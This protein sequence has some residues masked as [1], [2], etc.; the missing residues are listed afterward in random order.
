MLTPITL[1]K[2]I[3][4]IYP[5]TGQEKETE[6]Q[7]EKPQCIQGHSIAR[8]AAQGSRFRNQVCSPDTTVTHKFVHYS[9]LQGGEGGWGLGLCL[10]SQI[11][12]LGS[13]ASGPTLDP[14]PRP[15]SLRPDKTPGTSYHISPTPL[16][17]KALKEKSPIGLSGSCLSSSAIACNYGSI[18]HDASLVHKV[19]L[20]E[21]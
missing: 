7:R 20:G 8:T 4:A 14:S 11:T 5:A 1:L 15:V 13:H 12:L 10:R 16:Q 6:A 21:N 17:S 9:A 19:Y 18:L 3:C 2:S